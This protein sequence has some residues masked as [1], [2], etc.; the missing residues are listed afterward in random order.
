MQNCRTGLYRL[1][2][3]L[4][5]DWIEGDKT[6][7]GMNGV[8]VDNAIVWPPGRPPI[9]VAAYLSDSNGSPAALDAAH[10]KIG[11]AVALAVTS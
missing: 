2:A 4:P 8:A 6:G 9:L 11:H 3:G 10:A 1:R 5:P 7:T